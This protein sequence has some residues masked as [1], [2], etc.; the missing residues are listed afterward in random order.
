MWWGYL[1][2]GL[3]GAI[4]S[5]CRAALATWMAQ[6]LS[7]PFP[8]GTFVVN[9]SGCFVI[10]LVAATIGPQSKY[11]PVARPFLMVGMLGGYTTFSS[12]SL[13]TF[14]LVLGREWLWACCYAIA[15]TA[16][17]LIAVTVGHRLGEMV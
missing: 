13:E 7:S 16:M 14:N 9:V 8:W 2:V 15:S 6:R 5:I 17:C 4:G 12:F 10:G 11:Y 1:A 3:G